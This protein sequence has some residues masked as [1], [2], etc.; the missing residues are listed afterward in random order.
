VIY[1]GA[2]EATYMAV[3]G[4]TVALAAQMTPA[5]SIA[6]TSTPQE[7]GMNLAPRLQPG[8][9]TAWEMLPFVEV[10]EQPTPSLALTAT[11]PDPTSD[12]IA[13]GIMMLAFCLV[14]TAFLI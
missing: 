11:T 14:F 12:W 3:V 13:W 2:D 9:A 10:G 5:P 6:R 7:V 1:G 4:L 8:A